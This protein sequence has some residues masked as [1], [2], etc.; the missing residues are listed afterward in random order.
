[1]LK[2]HGSAQSGAHYRQHPAKYFGWGLSQCVVQN[3]KRKVIWCFGMDWDWILYY[4]GIVEMKIDSYFVEGEYW[5][6]LDMGTHLRERLRPGKRKIS[7]PS[8][9]KPYILFV[10]ADIQ[11]RCMQ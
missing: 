4:Q 7:W 9:H 5:S 6:G 2:L 1:M 10:H 11:E 3:W 8:S